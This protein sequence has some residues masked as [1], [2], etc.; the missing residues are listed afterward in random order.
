MVEVKSRKEIKREQI[1][2]AAADLFVEKGYTLASMDLIAKQAD[3]SKQTVYSHFGSK[4]ELFSATIKQK[5]D[6][7]QML[8]L[9]GADFAD[10]YAMLLTIGKRFLGMLTSK[11]ALAVHKICAFEARTYPKIS[12]LFYYAGPAQITAELTELMAQ[13]H[14]KKILNIAN[15]R[16]AALQFLNIIKGEIWL[17]VEFNIEQKVS[18]EEIADYLASSITFFLKGYAL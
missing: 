10:P 7:H 1:L 3:V 16:F 5:C 8:D 17:Q 11:E 12:E 13:F 15:P 2:K 14:Q 9:Q 6:S 4:E 18:D